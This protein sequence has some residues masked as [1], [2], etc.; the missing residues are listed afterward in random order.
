MVDR[1]VQARWRRTCSISPSC[2]LYL[3]SCG[4]KHGKENIFEKLFDDTGE[5][6]LARACL[7]QAH[8]S[9]HKAPAGTL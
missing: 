5:M 3:G 8:S 6:L 4:V 9:Y 7:L 1:P 2:N